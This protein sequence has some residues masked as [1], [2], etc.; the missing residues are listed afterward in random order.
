MPSDDRSVEIEEA[1][2]FRSLPP[3]QLVRLKPLL[4]QKPLT[5]GRQLYVEGK[6][7][8]ALWIVRRGRV[9]LY[10]ASLSGHVTTLEAL[11]PGEVFG[12]VSAIE[13]P[14]Y[15]SSA[16]AVTGGAVWTLPREAFL[17][18]LGEEPALAVEIL[19]IVSTRLREAHDRLRSFAHDPA[20]MRLARALLKAAPEGHAEIT[21]RA[22]AESAGTTVETAIRVLRRF[23]REGVV[24]G[25]VGALHVLDPVALRAL[26]GHRETE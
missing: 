23:E 9:R 8:E 26:A 11:G 1:E 5:R 18:L 20:P 24:R 25:E 17:R 3:Q 21:R 16:E 13:H 10:K 2:L 14:S 19:R 12:A 22:L 4:R 15:P 7:A 6:P